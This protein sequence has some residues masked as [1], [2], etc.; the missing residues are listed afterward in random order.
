MAP[1]VGIDVSR[2]LLDVAVRPSQQSRRLPNTAKGHR[3]L[4]RHLLPLQPYR[5]VVEGSG[6]LE[7][8]LVRALQDAGLPVVV[9]N[10]RQVRDFA[11]G[12]GHLVKTDPIDAG[13]L[14]HFAEVVPLPVPVPRTANE[15]TLQELVERR[16]QVVH[17]RTAENCRCDRAPAHTRPSIVRVLAFLEEEITALEQQIATLIA[18]DPQLCRDAEILRSVPGIGPIIAATLL[19]DLP[20]LGSLTRPQ[21]AALVGVAPYT[22]QSGL[23]KGQSSIR[24]GRAAVRAA[25]YLA[26][27]TAARCNPLIKQFHTRLTTVNK[28]HKVK[29]VACEHKLLTILNAIMRDGTTWNPEAHMG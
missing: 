19:A 10:P 16:R 29:I 8:Q 21:I 2:D 12:T 18:S 20:E 11:K 17:L 1:V 5:I 9:V 26:A 23:R 27:I 28:P 25:L 7:R 14:A 6:G 22:V 13:V 15:C 4:I 3:A 24:G